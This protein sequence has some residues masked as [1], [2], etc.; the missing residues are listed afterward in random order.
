MNAVGS[1]LSRGREH[2]DSKSWCWI[3]AIHSEIRM[4]GIWESIVSKIHIGRRSRL[5]SSISEE[6]RQ[7]RRLRT[8]GED[9]IAI[10]ICLGGRRWRRD[11]HTGTDQRRSQ[12]ERERVVE[13]GLYGI[14]AVRRIIGPG[15]AVPLL[16]NG[17]DKEK[18]SL[19]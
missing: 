3:D 9:K 14:T 5:C 19:V 15:I 7:R 13:D 8:R 6:K 1:L 10:Q 4:G 12:A 11:E 17:K 16:G 18:R 2:S